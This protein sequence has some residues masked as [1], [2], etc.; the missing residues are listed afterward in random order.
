MLQPVTCTSIC[1]T[2]VAYGDLFDWVFTFQK[3]LAYPGGLRPPDPS[4]VAAMLTAPL[5]ILMKIYNIGM[6]LQIVGQLVTTF[7]FYAINMGESKHIFISKHKSFCT[8]TSFSK[9]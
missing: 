8:K 7:D 1:T 2:P 4:F 6:Q 5:T 3:Y 9:I